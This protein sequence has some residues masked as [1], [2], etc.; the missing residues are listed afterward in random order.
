[1]C[2][3]CVL[4]RDFDIICLSSLTLQIQ[5][6]SLLKTAFKLIQKTHYTVLFIL[7]CICFQKPEYAHIETA[8]RNLLSLLTATVSQGQVQDQGQPQVQVQNQGQSSSQGTSQEL[9]VR[10]A[11]VQQ[12]MAKLEKLRCCYNV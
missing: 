1:M 6:C 4:V 5:M 9:R 7:V 12:E 8:A 2:K 11:N 10:P 3:M